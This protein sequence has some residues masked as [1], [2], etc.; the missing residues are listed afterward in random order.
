[1]FITVAQKSL[2]EV[3]KWLPIRPFLYLIGS[4]GAAD[5]RIHKLEIIKTQPYP[6]QEQ[7]SHAVSNVD[8]Y[9]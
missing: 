8:H 4:D 9:C 3:Y 6:L 1:M 7:F 5:Q 2:N